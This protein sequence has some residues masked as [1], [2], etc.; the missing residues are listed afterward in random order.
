MSTTEAL[1]SRLHGVAD[2]IPPCLDDLKGPEHG[3]VTLPTR[4]A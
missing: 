1:P 4:L 3:R 2:R